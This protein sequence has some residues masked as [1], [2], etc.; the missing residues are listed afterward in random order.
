M[1]VTPRVSHRW[2]AML[3]GV[4]ALFL[5]TP[6]SAEQSEVVCR[7]TDSRLTEISGMTASILHPHT[8]WLHNDTSGG[9]YIYAVDDRTCRTRARVRIK[10]AKARDFEAI[11]T[12]R[13][14]KGRPVIWL[15]DIGDNRDSWPYVEVLRIREPALLTSGAV[16]AKTFRFTYADRP[17]N[18]ETILADPASSR[19]WVVTKQLAHGS[20]YELPV[21]V[22]SNT[23][24]Q[25][26]KIR[27][28]DGLLTDGAI[29]PDGTRYVLR[30]YGD[31]VLYSGLPPER[32]LTRIPL[33]YQFQ[34][35]AMS[36][37]ADG[38]SLL[39]AGERDNRL[40]RVALPR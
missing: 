9:P 17:H 21:P 14:P 23:V 27:V 29:S 10:G 12:G 18:A 32:E 37:A 25:A 40:L 4:G 15:G 6:A 28:E 34:G 26:R 33:P 38:L 3:L 22:K 7:F 31:A 13:D 36:W 16:S 19:I 2:V 1:S 20:L 24:N 5:S 11:S 39:I 8:L 30:D 35:E